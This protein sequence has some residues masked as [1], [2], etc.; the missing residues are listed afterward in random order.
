MSY[1]PYTDRIRTIRIY[2]SVL[3]SVFLLQVAV[4]DTASIMEAFKA[5]DVPVTVV[6]KISGKDEIAV[7][8]MQGELQTVYGP[9]TDR[10]RTV[11]GRKDE[12][13]V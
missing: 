10:I 1:G 6:G 11:Y 13:A 2:G 12:I 5:A 9:Y 3:M 8:G 4:S 7:Y